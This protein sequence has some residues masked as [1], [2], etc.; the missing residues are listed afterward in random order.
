MCR[1]PPRST[2]TDTLVPYPTLFRSLLRGTAGP[3]DA[4]PVG[5]RLDQRAP[6]GRWAGATAAA[7]AVAGPATGG[8]HRGSGLVLGQRLSGRAGRPA[9]EISQA[10]VAR[11][12]AERATDSTYQT[13]RRP[14]VG[15]VGDRKSVV[16]GKSVSVRVDPGGRRIIKK[17][18]KN[19]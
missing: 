19:N 5:L 14:R 18:N 15:R 16:E 2:R 17:K 10:P 9:G 3:G 12:P 8:G 11:G 13:G 1:L 7:P 6:P 4:A